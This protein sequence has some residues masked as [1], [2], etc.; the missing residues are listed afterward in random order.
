MNEEISI[1]HEGV[2][3]TAEY[4]IFDDVLT[5]YLPDGS[6]SD[7]E[8]RGLKPESTARAHLRAYI[9]KNT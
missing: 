3:Y 7:T 1:E 2:V 8:L 5:V 4:S 9:K 6:T